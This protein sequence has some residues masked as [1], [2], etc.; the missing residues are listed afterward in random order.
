[1]GKRTN[2]EC[3]KCPNKDCSLL[4]YCNSTWLKFISEHKACTTYKKGQQIIYERMLV[5]GM[6]F[7]LSGKVKVYKTGINGKQQILRLSKTGDILGHRG[8]NRKVFPISA[9]ALE[10][11]K[12]CFIEI[13]DF[14]QILKSNP[15]MAYQLMAFYAE[16]LFISEVRA[17]NLAQLTVREKVADSLVK[18]RESFEVNTGNGPIGVELS[19]QEIADLAGTT[20]EQVSKHL[21]D[22]KDEG[23]IELNGRGINLLDEERLKTT[24][25]FLPEFG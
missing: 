9:A 5:D 10:D 16:E 2:I 1:M 12:V 4:R 17:R 6:Y 24:A 11:C 21:A 19:R 14:E 18:I 25:G 7:I 20:K 15:E 22:F 13:D 23:I 8:F 3:E